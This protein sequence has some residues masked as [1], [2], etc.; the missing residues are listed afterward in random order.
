MMPLA[1]DAPAFAPNA[2][3]RLTAPAAADTAWDTRLD[4]AAYTAPA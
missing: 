1:N 3:K 2:A 4:A